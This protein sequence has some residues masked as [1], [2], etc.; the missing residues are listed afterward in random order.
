M[1]DN[2]IPSLPIHTARLGSAK[3]LRDF[4]NRIEAGEVQFAL[5][6]VNYTAAGAEK[7]G[8]PHEHIAGF[9]KLPKGGAAPV[10]GG[11]RASYLFA[12]EKVVDLM[13]YRTHGR[14]NVETT[15]G[16]DD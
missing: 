10:L 8:H 11:L 5:C 16:S 7:F 9:I 6:Y 1:S 2:E 4:A 14:Y 12:E 13:N 3:T 15:E